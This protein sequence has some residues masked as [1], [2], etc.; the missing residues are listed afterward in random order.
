MSIESEHKKKILD[1]MEAER[2]LKL[3]RD[4]AKYMHLIIW[5]NI[6]LI[7]GFWLWNSEY[8]QFF[9]YAIFLVPYAIIT[10]LQ[11]TFEAMGRSTLWADLFSLYLISLVVT[12]PFFIPEMLLPVAVSYAVVLLMVGLL[13]GTR[14]LFVGAFISLVGFAASILVGDNF[15]KSLGFPPLDNAVSLIVTPA[16]SVFAMIATSIFYSSVLNGQAKLY[17]QVQLAHMER[18]WT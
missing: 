12:I 3:G 8:T 17:R 1:A 15:T 11:K 5:V 14:M 6:V 7:L 18:R 4:L 10:M 16:L 9:W 13:S 2:R